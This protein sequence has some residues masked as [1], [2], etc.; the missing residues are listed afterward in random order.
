MRTEIQGLGNHTC[1]D[2]GQTVRFV[3]IFDNRVK[4]YTVETSEVFP[5][6]IVASVFSQAMGPDTADRLDDARLD[7]NDLNKVE[8][9]I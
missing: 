5:P 3:A 7:I 8:D 1:R 6:D 4:E 2:F 9:W